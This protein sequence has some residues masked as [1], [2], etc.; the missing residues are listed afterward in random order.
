AFP[1][2]AARQRNGNDGGGVWHCR[3]RPYCLA[4]RHV[5]NTD[6]RDRLFPVNLSAREEACFAA[7]LA[8]RAALVAAGVCGRSSYRRRSA[9]RATSPPSSRRAAAL[10][11]R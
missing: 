1:Q 6:F 5:R 11:R 3:A 4:D 2:L 8:L 9:P 10:D 7:V